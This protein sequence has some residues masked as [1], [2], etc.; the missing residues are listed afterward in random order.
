M[1]KTFS[2]I[3]HQVIALDVKTNQNIWTF[4]KFSRFND[5]ELSKNPVYIDQAMDVLSM[6]FDEQEIDKLDR[7]SSN[8]DYMMP[9]YFR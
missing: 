9:D 2:C 6:I 3:E 8:G 5:Q 1:S 4:R 7:L